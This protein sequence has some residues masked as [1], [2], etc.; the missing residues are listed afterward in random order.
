MNRQPDFATGKLVDLDKPEEAVRQE[1]ERQLVNAYHYPKDHLDIEAQIPRGSG[2]FPDFA[3]IVIYRNGTDRDAASDILGIVELKR[4]DREDG[5]SQ[6]KSY[7]TATSAQWGVWTNGDTIH[8]VFRDPSDPTRIID[9]LVYTIPVFGQLVADVGNLSKDDLRPYHPA[10]LKLVFRRISNSIYANAS[11]GRREQLGAEMIK[12]IFAKILDETTYPDSPP[13]FRMQVGESPESVRE[14]IAGLF[15]RVVDYFQGDE[16]YAPHDELELDAQS[17]AEVVG[18]LERGSL[19]GTDAD[20]V[21]DAFEVFAQPRFAGERGQFFTPRGIVQLAIRL[22][23]PEPG[24]SICDP[25]CGTGGFLIHVLRHL[26]TSMR[27]DASGKW[28]RGANLEQHLRRVIESSVFGG[29]LD[30]D[31]VKIAKA[32]MVI[33]GDGRSNVQRRNSLD[34]EL[35]WGLPAFDVVV[36]NPPFGTTSKVAAVH[37]GAFEFGQKWRQDGKDGH[38]KPT[39]DAVDTDR[40]LLFLERCI[41]HL[42]IGGRLAI[43]LPETVF[44]APSLGWV[45][46]FIRSAGSVDAIV[47]LPHNSFRPHCNAKTCLMVLRRGVPQGD[48]VLATP[49]EMG[50]DLQGRPLYRLNDPD[51][52]WDDLEI[53]LG[54]LD[55][56]ASDKNEFTFVAG[57][58]VILD[59]ECWLPRYHRP[60]DDPGEGRRWTTLE[61]LVLDGAIEVFEG[62]GSPQ[63]NLKGTGKRP[64]IRVKDIINWEIN[65][66]PTAFVPHDS[67][68]RGAKAA[69]NRPVAVDDVIMVRRGSYR[70]GSVAIAAPRDVGAILT[71]ELLTLRVLPGNQFQLSGPYLLALLSSSDVQQQIPARI[72]IDTTLPNL[73]DRWL[74][75]RVPL[76]EKVDER[77]R[78]GNLAEAIITQRREALAAIERELATS[79]GGELR[80]SGMA[81]K[82]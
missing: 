21:G 36:T 28:G 62:H 75:L 80:L 65:H 66:D 23:D 68:V 17:V 79:F 15:R 50:H 64:Y 1:Y 46:Q 16:I 49:Q 13:D 51:D 30:P 76:H 40:Y 6:L 7:M 53:V 81:G 35:S 3:D 12:L 31:I 39:G 60:L 48:V 45:R 82:V 43:V 74:S 4:P 61:E 57:P 63:A 71:K 33:A 78:L 18:Q 8:Y 44:H 54:E 5:V 9:N 24:E 58:E 37:A 22:V 55:H 10:E 25:A 67:N 11:L 69:A 26:G 56:P 20:V 29:D 41:K 32:Y 2:H 38:W 72:G 70:I 27:S 19:T 73:G 59:D 14:R 77:V 52:L 47:D 34:T 42:K